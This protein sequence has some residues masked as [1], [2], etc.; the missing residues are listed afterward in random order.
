VR[1]M[2]AGDGLSP[3]SVRSPVCTHRTLPERLAE[4]YFRTARG[5]SERSREGT[6]SVDHRAAR[7]AYPAT[8]SGWA[9]VR[10]AG[11]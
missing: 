11:G 3:G 9:C 2:L 10:L 7:P 1:A 5:I 8:A 4:L 6:L